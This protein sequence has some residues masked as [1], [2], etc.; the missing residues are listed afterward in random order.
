MLPAPY[1]DRL[2]TQLQQLPELIAHA[3]LAL[4]P[5]AGPRGARVSGAT[6]TP[7][8]PCRLD[9]LD[10]LGPR[11]DNTPTLG[12][13][14]SWAETVLDDRRRAN[15]WS[16]WAILPTPTRAP[17]ELDSEH[18]ARTAIQYLLFHLAFAATRTYATD[19]ADEAG[20][21]HRH[22]SEVTGWYRLDK[23]A[24]R[25]A[26]AL[27]CPRCGLLSLSQAEGDDIRCSDDVC[28]VIM[29]QTEYDAR[30]EDY[31]ATAA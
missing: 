24:R 4:L 28:G 13:L 29:R 31:L 5:G 15:D 14:T 30:V 8:L 20:Q 7:P 23:P 25:R 18:Q 21:L 1:L 26:L 2:R 16:A 12:L 17:Y 9:V 10:D 19:L 3:H 27:P 11:R 6:R 22:L